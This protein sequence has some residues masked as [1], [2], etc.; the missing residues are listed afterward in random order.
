[1]AYTLGAL[2]TEVQTK[3]KDSTFPAALIKTYI[4]DTIDEVL[5]R[6]RFSFS[7]Q[8]LTATLDSGDTE[9]AF[10]A[11]VQTITDISYTTSA[12]TTQVYRPEY[13]SYRQFLAAYPNRTTATTGLPHRFTLYG[14]RLLL[15]APLSEGIT[16]T[17]LYVLASPTLSLDEDVPIIPVEYKQ[18]LVRGALANIEEYRENYDQ[19]AIH[20]RK[21]EDLTEDMLQRYGAR[22]FIT[23]PKSSMSRR[24]N[25]QESPWV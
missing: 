21:V 25:G 16:A 12:D 8:T 22:Q 10:A 3:A 2:V 7:E 17:I 24:R 20:K 19:A 5:G 23:A 6:H 18:L 9:Y 14:N 4:Q 15:P 1:M 11:T 13:L